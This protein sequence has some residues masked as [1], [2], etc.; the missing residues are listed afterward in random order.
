MMK[1]AVLYA[2][3]TK[4]IIGYSGNLD[5][6]MTVFQ[7]SPSPPARPISVDLSQWGR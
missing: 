3:N 1:S 4:K 6:G 7:V 2:E 5:W